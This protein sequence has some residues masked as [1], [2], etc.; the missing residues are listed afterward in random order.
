LPL[1]GDFTEQQ[2]CNSM[3]LLLLH[4]TREQ[5]A[6]LLSMEIIIDQHKTYRVCSYSGSGHTW[7]CSHF[8]CAQH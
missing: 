7:Y 8:S 4:Y 6:L 3:V 2:E 1:L 5:K